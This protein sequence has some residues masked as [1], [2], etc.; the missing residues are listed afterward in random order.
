[1]VLGSYLSHRFQDTFPHFIDSYFPL[2]DAVPQRLYFHSHKN[3][4]QIEILLFFLIGKSISEFKSHSFSILVESLVLGLQ[5]IDLSP[6]NM[7]SSSIV[8]ILFDFGTHFFVLL[9]T[10]LG[11]S[12]QSIEFLGQTRNSKNHKIFTFVQ[13][14]RSCS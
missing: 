5:S 7:N 2:L 10:L 14:C 8:L 1:M 13:D 6:Q 3:N 11:N 4:H 9:L 12:H